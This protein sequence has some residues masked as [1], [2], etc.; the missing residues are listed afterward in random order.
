MET[1][2]TFDFDG[3][4]KAINEGVGREEIMKKFNVPSKARYYQRR[5]EVLNLKQT[6]KK[7]TPEFFQVKAEPVAEPKRDLVVVTTL[8]NLKG[9]LEAF[10]E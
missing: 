9:V 8:A 4:K 10:G 7:K 6:T 3:F 2:S 5:A 1:R